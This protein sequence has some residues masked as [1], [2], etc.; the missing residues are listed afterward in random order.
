MDNSELEARVRGLEEDVAAMR[1]EAQERE[2]KR[3]K[4]GIGVLGAIVM[5]IGGWLWA[6]IKPL[7]SLNIGGK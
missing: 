7:I 6:E 2:I 1:T 5:A 3:L 4:W